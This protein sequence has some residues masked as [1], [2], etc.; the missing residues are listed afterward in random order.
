MAHRVGRKNAQEIEVNRE[1]PRGFG[2]ISERNQQ[3]DMSEMLE[4][5][6]TGPK[7]CENNLSGIFLC[8]FGGRLRQNYE[9]SKK[10][11]PQDLFCVIGGCRDL[12]LFHVE[13]R[14]IL[15]NSRENNSL[16][17]LLRN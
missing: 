8:N 1:L 10:L 5:Y 7:Y 9:I 12:R 13:L 16:R 4:D 3:E 17:I 2:Y 15:R 6:P 14:E 11:I